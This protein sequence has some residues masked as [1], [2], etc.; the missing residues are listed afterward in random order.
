MSPRTWFPKSGVFVS[1]LAIIVLEFESY[2]TCCE[3]HENVGPVVKSQA[4]NS[5]YVVNIY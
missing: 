2:T 1:K 3:T 5:L 4:T